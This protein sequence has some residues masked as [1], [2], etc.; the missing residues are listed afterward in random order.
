MG[1]RQWRHRCDIKNTITKQDEQDHIDLLHTEIEQQFDLGTGNLPA[2]DCTL[3]SYNILHLL[4]KSLAYK[5]GWLARIW[6]ARQ[7]AHRIAERDD[8]LIVQSKEASQVYQWCR[9]HKDQ[10]T[11]RKRR[12][13]TEQDTADDPEVEPSPNQKRRCNNAGMQETES[14]DTDPTDLQYIT[15]HEYCVQIL[16]EPIPAQG[17]HTIAE[18]NNQHIL[19]PSD[20]TDPPN[21]P[22]GGLTT[23]S[24]TPQ[25]DPFHI[26]RIY[27]PD[28]GYRS[29]FTT[30]RRL[31]DPELDGFTTHLPMDTDDHSPPH[32]DLRPRWAQPVPLAPGFTT[33]A[34]TA[35]RRRIYDPP[36]ASPDP[37]QRG[38][39]SSSVNNLQE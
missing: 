15:D 1:H 7:R 16:A 2:G 27:A 10:Q 29:G 11:H 37:P 12:R 39:T 25:S 4:E 3:L 5:K 28:D 31:P 36:I 14:S 26:A 34:P 20:N 13:Y 22:I 19:G 35:R 38:N 21:A 9:R 6:A 8:A 30:L 23:Q 18:C 24:Q 33:L 32:P 17:H